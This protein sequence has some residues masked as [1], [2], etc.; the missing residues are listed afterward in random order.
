MAPRLTVS[1]TSGAFGEVPAGT[2]SAPR[3]FEFTNSGGQYTGTIEVVIEG[4]LFR[5]VANTCAMDSLYAGSACFVEVVFAPTSVAGTTGRLVVRATPGGEVAVTLTGTGISPTTAALTVS[6]SGTGR[7]RITGMGIDC[8]ADCTEDGPIGRTVTLAAVAEA[9]S[10][11]AGW[12]GC[13]STMDANC[14]VTLGT[15]RTVT[16]NFIDTSMGAVT[17]TVNKDGTGSGTVSGTGIACGADCTEMLGRGTQVTL[18]A[19]PATTSVFAGWVGCDTTSGTSCT[20]TLTANRTITATFDV[21]SSAY[22]L[23]VVKAGTGM[24]TVTGTGIACGTDCSEQVPAG[25]LRT[26]TAMP[27]AGSL[28]GGWMGCDM[29]AGQ[30]CIVTL[31]SNR[32]VTATFTANPTPTAPTMLTALGTTS[33]AVELRWMDTSSN[34]LDFRVDRSAQAT[35]GFA[36]IATVAANATMA[37]IPG[38]MQ[39]THYFRV[40]ATN[41]AG[42]SG[43]SNTAIV[44]LGPPAFTLTVMKAGPGNGTIISSPVGISC[45]TDCSEPYPQGSTVVLSAINQSGSTFD[46]WTGCSSTA[47]ASCTILLNASATVTATFGLQVSPITLSV[48]S[49]SMT[50]AYTVSWTC[51]PGV[52]GSMFSLEEDVSSSFPGPTQIAVTGTTQSFVGK[53]NGFYCYRVRDGA[54]PWSNVGCITVAR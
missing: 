51:P 11:F 27:A 44:T 41:A 3:R 53:P 25:Q 36:E 37:T 12:T 5:A 2:T 34:E 7:G 45:G 46:S 31:G 30:D 23:T 17:L 10:T 33:G 9:G 18:T 1:Q 42:S 43:A 50:G 52:C 19:T 38:L 14:T 48:P 16:A 28:H 32:T 39:G 47:G 54:G 29:V 8:G 24:G 26:V 22:Q 4:A 15:A 49:S 35:M 40:R 13:D 6:K 21:S 20:V